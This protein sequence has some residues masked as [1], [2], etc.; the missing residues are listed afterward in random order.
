MKTSYLHEAVLVFSGA[1]VAGGV[2]GH[3]QEGV[4][5]EGSGVDVTDRQEVRHVPPG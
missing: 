2:K 1:V 4:R 3:V 5:P